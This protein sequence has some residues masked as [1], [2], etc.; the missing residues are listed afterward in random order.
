M[1]AGHD[2]QGGEA[3]RLGRRRTRLRERR[4][5]VNRGLLDLGAQAGVMLPLGSTFGAAATH[6]RSMVSA[7]LLGIAIDARLAA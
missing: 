1:L 2:C 5:V 4:S 3:G 6:Q 7:A